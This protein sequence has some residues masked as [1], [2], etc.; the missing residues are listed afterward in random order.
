MKQHG[1]KDITIYNIQKT[2]TDQKETLAGNRYKGPGNT[3]K[4]V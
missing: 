3:L 4:H 2:K 1:D